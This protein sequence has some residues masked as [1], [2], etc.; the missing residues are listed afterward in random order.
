MESFQISGWGVGWGS[1]SYLECNRAFPVKNKGNESLQRNISVCSNGEWRLRTVLEE[2]VKCV[3]Q[4][5][6]TRLVWRIFTSADRHFYYNK[7]TFIIIRS[8]FARQGSFLHRKWHSFDE[9]C[10]KSIYNFRG[11]HDTRKEYFAFPFPFRLEIIPSL[12]HACEIPKISIYFYLNRNKYIPLNKNVN[13]L[14][15]K[16]C[17]TLHPSYMLIANVA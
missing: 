7:I 11:C 8:L 1:L 16:Y 13:I 2:A 10:K 12:I 6:V 3:H 9:L 15:G 4:D 5:N 17:L 14:R